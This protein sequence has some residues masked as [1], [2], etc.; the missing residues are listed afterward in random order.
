MD[1]ETELYIAQWA[2]DLVN[3][4]FPDATSDERIK[5]NNRYEY[6]IRDYCRTITDNDR[7]IEDEDG[8]VKLKRQEYLYLMRERDC[9]ALDDMKFQMG[10]IRDAYYKNKKKSKS[11]NKETEEY[12]K[13][14]ANEMFKRDFPDG[15]P[16]DRIRFVYQY[17]RVI[18]D[19]HKAVNVDTDEVFRSANQEDYVTITRDKYN[20]LFE[21]AKRLDKIESEITKMRQTTNE[22]RWKMIFSMLDNAKAKM[23]NDYDE[24]GGKVSNEMVDDIRTYITQ[25]ISNIVNCNVI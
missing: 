12:I 6:L 16:I 4:D 11:I 7:V 5:L 18:E 14:L 21:R 9:N 17:K 8:Y 25:S 19:F 23:R 10:L 15:T 22:T 2:G 24:C 3:K 13:E 20:F 1:N